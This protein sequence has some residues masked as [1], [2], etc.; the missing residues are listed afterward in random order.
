MFTP[1]S[2]GMIVMT[3]E[4]RQLQA[5]LQLDEPSQKLSQVSIKN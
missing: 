1:L 2:S 5:Y 3:H 4:G